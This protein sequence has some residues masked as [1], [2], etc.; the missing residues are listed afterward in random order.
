MGVRDRPRP[1]KMAVRVEVAFYPRKTT[2]WPYI[3]GT[4]FLEFDA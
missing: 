3:M 4:E 1:T 2:E